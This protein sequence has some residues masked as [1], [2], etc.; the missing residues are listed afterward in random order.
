[1]N[2]F[3]AVSI[4]FL[5]FLLF[6]FTASGLVH[7]QERFVDNADGT[8]TDTLLNV[9]WAKTDNQGDINWRQAQ[10]W[11]KYTFPYTLSISY[12]NWRLPSIDEL[13]TLSDRNTQGY[14][15]DCGQKVKIVS[16][17]EL[18]CGWVWASEMKFISARLFNFHRGYS[19][20]DRISKYKAYRVL[21]VRD[22]E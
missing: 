22:L 19:Y 11:V 20:T 13:K 17:I 8:V 4:F 7:A 1:M 16:V 15:T 9:M 10:K 2:K 12:D 18:T 6:I 14:E 21:A 5:V 3:A